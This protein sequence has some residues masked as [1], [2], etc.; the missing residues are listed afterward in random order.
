MVSEHRGISINESPIL[1]QCDWRRSFTYQFSS[2]IA[3]AVTLTMKLPVRYGTLAL[4]ASSLPSTVAFVVLTQAASMTSAASVHIQGSLVER[5]TKIPT[6]QKELKIEDQI[7]VTC[8]LE[9]YSL[10]Q[11]CGKFLLLPNQGTVL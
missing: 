4:G 7:Y 2:S 5:L 9:R 6:F 8:T 11:V 10:G 1:T 3:S